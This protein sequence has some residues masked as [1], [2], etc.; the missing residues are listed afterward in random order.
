MLDEIVNL[1]KNNQV[2]FIEPTSLSNTVMAS[3]YYIDPL[4]EKLKRMRLEKNEAEEIKTIS[5]YNDDGI[6]ESILLE[7]TIG[8]TK[9]YFS[10]TTRVPNR[11]DMIKIK[12]W[13]EEKGKINSLEDIY[14]I[15]CM[16]VG[17]EDIMPDAEDL[18]PFEIMNFK[19]FGLPP[20]YRDLNPEELQIITKMGGMIYPLTE[21]E[22]QKLLEEYK[23]LNKEYHRTN[24][25]EKGIA[26][27]L[28]VKERQL[29][30][31]K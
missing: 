9:K 6:E 2:T 28:A 12:R 13:G 20:I 18:D 15:R 5:V 10:R 23:R 7:Q 3:K 21:I 17:L 24:A 29:G 14:Q 22:R 19:R 31:E 25:F 26:K 16:K 11:I 8:N 27:A 4:D 1:E 30:E